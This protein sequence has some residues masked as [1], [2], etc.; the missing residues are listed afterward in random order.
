MSELQ[1]GNSEPNSRPGI[2]TAVAQLQFQC[3]ITLELQ[4]GSSNPNDGLLELLSPTTVP[5]AT[6][7]P[8]PDL[9]SEPLSENS[10]SDGRSGAGTAVV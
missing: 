2:R 6:V 8:A 1:S 10:N 5:M 4:L 3:L 9:S 7:V